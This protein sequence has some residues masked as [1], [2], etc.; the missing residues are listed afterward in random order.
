MK[1]HELGVVVVAGVALLAWFLRAASGDDKDKAAAGPSLEGEPGSE[2]P[3][4]AEE[5]LTEEEIAE[6]SQLTVI[7]SEGSAFVPRDHGVQLLPPA[8]PDEM[9]MQAAQ[10]R[11]AEGGGLPGIAI[12]PGDLLAVRVVRGAP[13][14]DPWRLEG[15]GRD[16]EYQTWA[17]ET[18]DAA[19]AAREMLERLVVRPPRDEYGEPAP[20]TDAD[21]VE[22]KRVVDETI[23]EL[24]NMPEA[25][26]DGPE[27]PNR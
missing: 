8:S 17:F 20:L 12:A 26:D 3:W 21:F 6:T 15:L 2:P 10:A 13:D 16:R 4:P 23:E 1:P 9:A 18:E 19:R 11:R 25:E 24:A 27:S 14:V 7:T 5:D 22:A